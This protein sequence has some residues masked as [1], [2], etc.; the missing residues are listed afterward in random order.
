MQNWILFTVHDSRVSKNMLLWAS[1]GGGGATAAVVVIQRKFS[2]TLQNN[3]GGGEA[4][5][6]VCRR[7]CVCV[8][9]GSYR[10]FTLHGNQ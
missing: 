4:T 10:C 7:A 1:V 2:V 9:G 6:P 8:G 5:A 3:E